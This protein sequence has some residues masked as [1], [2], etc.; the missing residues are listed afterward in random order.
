MCV[1]VCVCVCVP[2]CVCVC[3]TKAGKNGQTS[4]GEALSSCGIEQWNQTMEQG[5][6]SFA[7]LVS[8]KFNLKI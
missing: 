4:E 6:G 1:C 5:C 2:V 8:A 3:M 7:L